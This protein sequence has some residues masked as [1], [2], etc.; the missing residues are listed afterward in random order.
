MTSWVLDVS[1]I[2]VLSVSQLLRALGSSWRF[3]YDFKLLSASVSVFASLKNSLKLH[4]LLG[5]SAYDSVNSLWNCSKFSSLFITVVCNSD[6][7]LEHDGIINERFLKINL[8][9]QV[10]FTLKVQRPS[11]QAGMCRSLDELLYN[12]RT[13]WGT[14]LKLLSCQQNFLKNIFRS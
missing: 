5:T 4:S 10:V 7:S 14:E 13:I 8:F 1:L 11:A 9:S 2:L 12:S 6:W 3:L